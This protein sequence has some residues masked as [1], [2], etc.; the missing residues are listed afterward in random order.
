[1]RASRSGRVLARPNTRSSLAREAVHRRVPV[2]PVRP[3]ASA[4]G[5]RRFHRRFRPPP[6]LLSSRAAHAAAVRRR[7]P[8]LPLLPLLPRLPPLAPAVPASAVD[9]RRF[10]R[11]FRLPPQLLSSRAAHTLPIYALHQPHLFGP[12]PLAVWYR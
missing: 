7:L 4:V 5:P 2:L 9:P 12:L 11:R 1:M 6:Q 8:L 3:P 10:H